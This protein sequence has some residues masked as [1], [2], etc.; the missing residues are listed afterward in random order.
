MRDYFM[1][2]RKGIAG[3]DA[4]IKTPVHDE[5][6]LVYAD[7]TASGRIYEPIEERLK[8]YVYPHVANTH[9]DTNFTA[10]KM[11]AAYERAAAIVKE[12][13]GAN[14]NDVL[15]WTGNG[16]TAAVNKLQRLLGWRL[17]EAWKKQLSIAEEDRPLVLITHMEHHSNHTSWL[18]TIAEVMVVPPAEDGSVSIENFKKILEQHQHRKWKVAAITACSNVT[19]IITPYM[20]IAALMHEAG[21]WCFVDFACSAPYVTINMHEDDARGRYLDAIFFSPHKFL[22]G[23]GSAGVLVF[24]KRLYGNEVPDHPGGGTVTWTNPWGGRRYFSD[25]EVR[26][27]GGTPGFLQAMRAA[28]A[29]RLKEEM[30]VENMWQREKR[31]LG[32]L[33][34]G[35]EAIDGVHILA[36]KHRHRLG[37]VSFYIEDLHHILAVKMLNDYF[38]IQV[39]GGCSCAGTYGHYLLDVNKEQSKRI[40]D[41]IDQ[42]DYSLKPGWVRFSLHPT[43]TEEEVEYM[44]KAVRELVQHH[45]SWKQHYFFDPVKG[46]VAH[47]QEPRQLHGELAQLYAPFLLPETHKS[48]KI[49]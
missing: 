25:V 13:V 15:I 45:H 33:W 31:L 39:R 20:D 28:L 29:I 27:D 8:K 40:T 6:P 9:T 2:F 36:K 7:W 22:G 18:E 17:H 47:K 11:T 24:N 41:R 46:K 16:M 32:I 14:A 4:K 34:E 38:G 3:H 48:V 5:I 12:H 23:P 19:G 37:I 1:Q 35:L 49:I 43:H 26:E 10:S 42:G 30:G 21:G 44:V